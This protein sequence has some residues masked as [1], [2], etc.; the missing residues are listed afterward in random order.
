MDENLYFLKY[1]NLKA[2][3]AVV[4]G[5]KLDISRAE[6][7]QRKFLWYPRKKNIG[8]LFFIF[9]LILKG[10]TEVGT[11]GTSYISPKREIGSVDRSCGRTSSS[12]TLKNLLKIIRASSFFFILGYFWEHDRRK[13]IFCVSRPFWMLPYF[14]GNSDLP[15][16]PYEF[17]IL[18]GSGYFYIQKNQKLMK[19]I[20]NIH[21]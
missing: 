19:T 2:D 9:S 8:D 12:V 6:P 16:N 17:R 15:Q 4:V 21:I 7:L 1:H 5:F 14:Y 10:G 20:K 3:A 18:E 11:I 13:K